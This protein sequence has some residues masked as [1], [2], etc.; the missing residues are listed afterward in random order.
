MRY[1]PRELIKEQKESKG[2]SYSNSWFLK[3]EIKQLLMVQFS[4][5]SSCRDK[6]AERIGKLRGP[7]KGLTK[8][9]EKA[10][11]TILS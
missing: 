5:E 6:I 4:R 9:V 3:G 1:R 11:A 8:V 10:G 7:D 2:G